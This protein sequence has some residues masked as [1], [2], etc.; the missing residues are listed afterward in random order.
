MR[1]YTRRVNSGSKDS[2]SISCFNPLKAP[3]ASPTTAV[4]KFYHK[5]LR[6]FIIHLD[7]GDTLL[8]AFLFLERC[9]QAST[10]QIRQ[11]WCQSKELVPPS[12]TSVNQRL[13]GLHAYRSTDDSNAAASP[14]SQHGWG[15]T[16]IATLELP[17]WLAGGTQW[18]LSA[19]P[20]TAHWFYSLGKGLCKSY[21]FQE[22][23][24][25]PSFLYF[26]SLM[27]LLEEGLAR[28][29]T[30]ESWITGPKSHIVEVEL[31]V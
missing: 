15:H 3:L 21:S 18:R 7:V 20:A 17:A 22:F 4:T 19:C 26:P 16:K 6:A 24:G 23:P 8:D 28:A 10:H 11:R 13:G 30:R 31:W 12:P 25:S 1:T 29:L 2:N 14:E 9:E 27:S 5:Y